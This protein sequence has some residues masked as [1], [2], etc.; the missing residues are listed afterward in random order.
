MP[1]DLQNQW[2]DYKDYFKGMT[3][4]PSRQGY[5]PND[6]NT[7]RGAATGALAGARRSTL[8]DVNRNIA[9]QGMGRTG[10]GMR[11][12]MN[13]GRDYASQ[14]RQ[15]NNYIDIKNAEAKRSDFWNASD[16]WGRG[17]SGQRETQGRGVL[18]TIKSIMDIINSLP[19]IG[20][21]A[22][23]APT[24][25]SSGTAGSIPGGTTGRETK[26]PTSEPPTDPWLPPAEDLVKDIPSNPAYPPFDWGSII[27]TPEPISEPPSNPTPPGPAYDD[28]P[29]SGPFENPHSELGGITYPESGGVY[30]PDDSDYD[31]G[32]PYEEGGG[33]S[34]IDEGSE[35]YGGGI[36]WGIADPSYGSDG[37]YNGGV[38]PYTGLV[39]IGDHYYTPDEL[40]AIGGWG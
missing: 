40:D 12:A 25:P 37:D 4:D 29:V 10:M 24:T 1:N 35:P 15:A 21:G 20:I 7:M 23:K 17:I 34:P 6:V 14:Q 5:S 38:D 18:D 26:P 33:W 2:I 39:R 27:G 22:P 3:L 11:A 32:L 13:L 16:R 28:F 31:V 36:N 8:Q 19:K 9:S 30:A